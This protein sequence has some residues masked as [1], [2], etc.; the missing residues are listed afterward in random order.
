MKA[1]HAIAKRGYMSQP[2]TGHYVDCRCGRTGGLFRTKEEATADHRAHI[3]E[4]TP[5]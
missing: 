2:A 4:V 1:Q 3:E 5:R